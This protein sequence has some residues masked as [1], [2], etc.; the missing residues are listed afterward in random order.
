MLRSHPWWVLHGAGLCSLSIRIGLSHCCITGLAS[1]SWG[2]CLLIL[3]CHIM[4]RR[5]PWPSL[6]HGVV[7]V[8]CL[9]LLTDW[10]DVC[11]L[12][13]DHRSSLLEDDSLMCLVIVCLHGTSYPMTDLYYYLY[14]WLSSS[15]TTPPLVATVLGSW[16]YSYW[17]NNC[18]IRCLSYYL[19]YLD[20]SASGSR[21]YIRADVA[22]SNMYK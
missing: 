6:M 21:R 4:S 20:H 19:R 13:H 1:R 15:T 17:F 12:C 11:V 5:L 22:L 9:L 14:D 16:H 3:C 18:F 7:L 10:L 2:P 8:H